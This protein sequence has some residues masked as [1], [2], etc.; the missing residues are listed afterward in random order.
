MSQ[1]TTYN[2]HKIIT[3]YYFEYDIDLHNAYKM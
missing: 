3:N 2:F 1:F